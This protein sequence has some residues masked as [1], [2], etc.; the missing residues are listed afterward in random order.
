MDSPPVLSAVRNHVGHLTLNN[1]QGLNALTLPM[2]RLAFKQLKAWHD[3]PDIVAVVLR[4]TGDRAF[5]AGGDI[6][7]LYDSYL[8]GQST[9]V[10]FFDEEYALDQFIYDYEKPIVAL[11]DGFVLGGGMG[12]VQGAA[13]RVLTERTKMG[14]PEVAIGYFP[15]VGA[16]HFLSRLPGELGIYLG[17]TGRHV[18]AADA[19]YAGLADWCISS[20]LIPALDKVLDTVCWKGSVTESLSEMLKTLAVK[21]LPGSELK[22]FRE[23]ISEHFSSPDMASLRQALEGEQ[24]PAYKDW[25]EETL[26]SLD[27]YSPL[28]MAVTLELL[29][30]GKALSLNDCLRLELHLNHQWFSKGDI[31]E[32]VRALIVDKDKQPR[33]NPPSSSAVSSERIG[34]F[35]NHFD[36]KP[37][38]Q[39]MPNEVHHAGR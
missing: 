4:A 22:A 24:R 10:Q 11:M 25:A 38:A 9:H 33:W 5:C 18:R 6:R 19:L 14:M 17:V 35:F 16:S 23:A 32:G 2:I 7:A 3:D 12:L 29:R 30:R 28:A 1:P 26:A 27:C 39:A 13:F 21:R 31:I 36:V 8:S 37:T 34:E 20:E 15:D